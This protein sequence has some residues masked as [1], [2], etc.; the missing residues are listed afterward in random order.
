MPAVVESGERLP[1]GQLTE[2]TCS[3]GDTLFQVGVEP[4]YPI[5]RLLMLICHPVERNRQAS[6]LIPGALGNANIQIPLRK[7]A[8]LH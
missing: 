7:T 5:V 4:N 8:S 6:D 1:G 2:L 3:L